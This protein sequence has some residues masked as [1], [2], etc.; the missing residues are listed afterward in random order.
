MPQFQ[1]DNDAQEK[2]S[3]VKVG[4]ILFSGLTVEKTNPKLEEVMEEA[5]STVSGKFSTPESILSD[6]VVQGCRALFS[7]LGLDPTKERPSGEALIRRVS[8]G[9][10]IYRINTVVDVNNAISLL[11]ACPCGAYNADKIKGK[12]SFIIG[13]KGENYQGI[14]NRKL[15]AE[16]KLLTKDEL[17]IFGGPTAD[18]AR[19]A[20]APDTKNVLML[21]YLPPGSSEE[22]LQ[23]AMELAKEKMVQVT[24]CKLSESGIYKI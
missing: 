16:N 14:G 7:K 22:I 1:T 12:I 19:T 21:I 15:D 3:E 17:S 10:G 20:I 9:N 23:S 24:G 2:L 4:Y 6:P 5:I 11:S 8:A 13:K 18:S